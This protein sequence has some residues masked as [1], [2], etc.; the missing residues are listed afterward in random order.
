MFVV[1]SQQWIGALATRACAAERSV[2]AAVVVVAAEIVVFVLW[3]RAR[4][5]P[6]N[7]TPKGGGA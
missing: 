6:E 4:R 1:I 5:G 2:A 7:S 3:F